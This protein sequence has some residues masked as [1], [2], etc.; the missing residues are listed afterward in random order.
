MN[1]YFMSGIISTL[2]GLKRT[3]PKCKRDQVVPSDKK[4]EKVYCK[5]CGAGIPP[6]KR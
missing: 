1:P 6:A 2:F 5:F 4:H 3:C